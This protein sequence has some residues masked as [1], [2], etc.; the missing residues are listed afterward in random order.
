MWEFLFFPSKFCKFLPCLNISKLLHT[1]WFSLS[2]Q[3]KATLLI[4]LSGFQ[5]LAYFLPSCKIMLCKT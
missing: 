2:I 5:K 3:R 4:D 1:P